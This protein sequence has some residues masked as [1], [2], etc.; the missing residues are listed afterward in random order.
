MTGHRVRMLYRSRQS[1]DHPKES[2]REHSEAPKSTTD[3]ESQNNDR[4][5]EE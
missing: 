4:Q 1:Q 2:D 5:E 3:A